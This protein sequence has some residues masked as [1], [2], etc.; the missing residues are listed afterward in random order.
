MKK[1]MLH[2]LIAFFLVFLPMAA[3]PAPA[4]PVLVE[5][6]YMNHGPLRPTLKEIRSIFSVY[7]NEIAVTWNDFESPEGEKFM[8]RKGISRHVPLVVWIDGKTTATIKGKEIQ[9]VGFPT[10]T[11]PASFQGKWSLDDLRTALDQAMQKK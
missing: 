3:L 9:F 2:G 4:P 8:A 6:L 11:G 5:V 1:I 7:G 10:G